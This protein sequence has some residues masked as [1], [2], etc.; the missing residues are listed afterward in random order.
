MNQKIAQ[1]LKAANNASQAGLT[2]AG[3]ALKKHG[4]RAESIFPKVTGNQAIINVQ[5]ERTL[6][7]ILTN[8][9]IER[10]ATSNRAGRYGGNII[11]Y[12][13]PDGKGARFN[14]DKSEFTSF[15]ES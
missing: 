13:I 2:A 6:R 12:E 1:L 5:G 3:R 7:E 11:N 8:P 4:D 14:A 10:T 9:N 15:L